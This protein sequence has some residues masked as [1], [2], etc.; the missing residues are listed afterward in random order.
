MRVIAFLAF[1]IGW[2][3]VGYG[4]FWVWFKGVCPVG[5]CS[6]FF[7]LIYLPSILVGLF[8]WAILGVTLS[9]VIIAVLP[10]RRPVPIPPEGRYSTGQEIQ[11]G[12]RVRM[13]TSPETEGDVVHLPA[14]GQV[15]SGY[16]PS[17]S[18]QLAVGFVVR[19]RDG[20]LHHYLVANPHVV[21]LARS[22]GATAGKS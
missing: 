20:E 14:R 12:D 13:G 3:I 4:A 15:Q 11:L 10:S 2:L 18:S 16:D 6:G 7:V 21:L 9:I 17:K 8:V 1:W 22:G 19:G 5:G